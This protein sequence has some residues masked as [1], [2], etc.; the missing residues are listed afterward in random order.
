VAPADDEF[1]LAV[2]V[3]V[4]QHGGLETPHVFVAFGDDDLAGCER[5]RRE[6]GEQQHACRTGSRRD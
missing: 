2:V 3:H 1:F 5:G 6:Q 4:P